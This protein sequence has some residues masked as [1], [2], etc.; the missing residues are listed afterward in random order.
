MNRLHE[1][2]GAGGNGRELTVR[3]DSAPGTPLRIP[4]GNGPELTVR[5]DGA[6]DRG[7]G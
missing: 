5:P 6:A 4:G 2:R 1:S 7:H 3:P